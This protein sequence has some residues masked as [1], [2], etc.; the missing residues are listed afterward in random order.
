MAEFI[1]VDHFVDL[2]ATNAEKSEFIKQVEEM[3]AKVKAVGDLEI[4]LSGASG[5][6]E[7]LKAMAELTKRQQDLIKQTK[8]Y[9][10]AVLDKAKADNLAA[11]ATEKLSRAELNQAKAATQNAKTAQIQARLTQQVT[12]EKEKIVKASEAE[13]KKQER[14]SNAYEQLKAKYNIAANTAKRLAAEEL[15]V[16]AAHGLLSNE[17]KEAAANTLLAQ[18]AAQKY[19]LEL[20]KIE[21]AVGQSQRKVGQYE[22]ATFALTQVLREAPAFAISFQTGVS[23]LSN[24]LPIL[25]DQFKNLATQLGSN[26][27]A[28]GIMAKSLLS[29]TGLLPIGLL[30]VQL[31]SKQIGEFFSKLFGG[32]KAIDELRAKQQT[33]NKAFSDSSYAEAVKNVNE[34]TINI[35]LAKEGFIDKNLVLNQYNKTLG[36]SIGKANSLNEAEQLLIKNGQ[37][38]IQMTLFKAAANE[39]LSE[40]AKKAVEIQKN[41][42]ERS[43]EAN[44]D[45]R[46]D[47]FKNATKEEIAEYNKISDAAEKA[48][49]ANDKKVADAL[50]KSRD[51][52]FQTFVERGADKNLKKDQDT[53]LSI[54]ETFQRRAAEIAKGFKLDLFGGQF[55]D[56]SKKE[57]DRED[58]K[59]DLEKELQERLK[60]QNDITRT[61]LEG[62]AAQ[63]LAAAQKERQLEIRKGESLEAFTQRQNAAFD[64]QLQ[65]YVAYYAKVEELTKFNTQAELA[66]LELRTAAEKREVEEKLK[67]KDLTAAQRKDLQD[68]IKAIDE[69]AVEERKL[70]ELKGNQ[71]I[72]AFD[73]E[74]EGLITGLIKEQTDERIKAR[75]EYFQKLKELLQ[76]ELELQQNSLSILRAD[77]LKELNK[78]VRNQTITIEEYNRKK[79]E[80]SRKYTL[81]ELDNQLDYYEKLLKMTA[82]TEEE[83]REIEAKIAELRLK[84]DQ[85]VTDA[86]I[87]NMQKL[88]DAQKRL[89]EEAFNTFTS[90]VLGSYDREK[91]AIQDIIDAL[92]EKKRKDIEVARST[93]ATAQEA[94]DRIAVINTQAQ[95]EREA[96]E[97]R[98]RQIDQEKARFEK[99]ANIAKIITDTASAV[100][101]ALPNV[102]L[103]VT[104]G[105]IGALQLARV[106]STP[107]PRY[108]HGLDQAKEDHIAFVGDGG[109]REAVRYA[110]GSTWITPDRPTLTII[111]KGAS[112][113]PDIDQQAAAFF[114]LAPGFTSTISDNGMGQLVGVM[115]TEGRKTRAAISDKKETHLSIKNGVITMSTKDGY[116]ETTYLN[117]NLGF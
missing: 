10:K 18:Q 8:A 2:E 41:A 27:K 79:L 1:K 103:A 45:L 47:A 17:Y 15:Q 99:V 30:V 83:R 31:F 82:K 114:N 44:T 49:F 87:D 4:K 9:E 60:L 91:N 76:K 66:E 92:E 35:K 37:A 61:R 24:N 6:K 67:Q 64:E 43:P 50:F 65:Q 20:I 62:E 93:S 98:Q 108:K 19:Y 73:R 77:E 69:K 22:N 106:L 70:I 21:D 13:L 12:K 78:Q 16:A 28:F 7:T 74:Y 72:L 3:I 26:T 55:D 14:L 117:Q 5:A 111:P 115:K 40:A 100:V 84:K 89:G 42:V 101:E 56:K 112:V 32:A 52:L 102:P 36:D 96:L 71:A 110:D 54:A 105:A 46:R 25:F 58:F 75:L 53:L 51:Q 116:N 23:A 88:A 109:K 81:E 39:A 97:R 85:E 107:V 57:K 29:F 59:K 104:V 38:Y 113:I 94:A 68:T 86:K 63:L 48:F 80:I 90:L 33:L 34:L 11:A 95:A